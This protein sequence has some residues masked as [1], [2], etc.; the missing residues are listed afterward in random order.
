MF[1]ISWFS[2]TSKQKYVLVN[3]HAEGDVVGIKLIQKILGVTVNEWIENKL[4]LA[5]LPEPHCCVYF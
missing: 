2:V 5:A 3:K 4:L 1:G